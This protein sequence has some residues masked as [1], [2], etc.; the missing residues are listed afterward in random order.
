VAAPARAQE[1]DVSAGVQEASHDDAKLRPA[2]PDFTIINLPTTLPLPVHGGDFHLT[3][4][5]G[6]NLLNDRFSELASNLFGIDEG[7]TIEFG[8][9]FGVMKHLEAIAARTNFNKV[10]Q[11]SAKYDPIHQDDT[12]WLGLSGI[13][14]VE[15]ANNF[16]ENYE[17]ALG[18]SI[19]RAFGDIA[20][21]Y[22]VPFWVHN[23]AAGTGVIRETVFIGLG[24]RV[25]FMPGAYL[26]AEVSPR[27]G[28]YRP[29]DSEFAFGIEKRIGGHVFSLVFANMPGTTFGQLAAGGFP[30]NLQ[31]GFNL[32]RKFF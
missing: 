3:H 30:H 6:E 20:A 27:P 15:G 11:L 29:G 14:S 5:F 8:Y 28:G 2:E 22:V 25:S 16:Q 10:I 23:S 31:M 17:P 32:T 26:T 9:R 24:A 19:S 21:V 18:A 13:L 4:R 12:H 1:P 7:A